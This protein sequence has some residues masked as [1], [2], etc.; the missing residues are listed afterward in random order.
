M[1]HTPCNA[2]PALAGRV[3]VTVDALG[4]GSLLEQPENIMT[5]R[6]KKIDNVSQRKVDLP[7]ARTILFPIISLPF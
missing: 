4:A 6:I 1:A 7:K 3:V 2:E 5:S